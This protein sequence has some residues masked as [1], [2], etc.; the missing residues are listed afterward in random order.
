MGGQGSG[1]KPSANTIVKRQ[2]SQQ[3]PV[4]DSVFLPDY[5]GV[6]D[7]ALKTSTALAGSSLWEVD[8]T[9][10]QLI[11]ADEID[12]QSKNIINV[13]D[14]SGAQDAATK[15][16][17][18]L[19]DTAAVLS[20]FPVFNTSGSQIDKGKAVYVTGWNVGQSAIN[21]ELAD[22]NDPAKMPSIG[23]ASAD[24]PNGM[25]GFVIN[26]GTLTGVN[27][28]AWNEGDELWIDDATAGDL[29]STK[30]LTVGTAIQ[31]IAQVGRDNAAGVLIVFGAGRS[32]DVPNSFV[33]S[34][35]M[36]GANV[37]GQTSVS[38]AAMFEGNSNLGD[39][40]RTLSGSHDTLSGSYATTSG[41]FTTLS[42]SHA[43]LS[44]A[45]VAHG[46]S[47]TA[48]FTGD[49]TSSGAVMTSNIIYSTTAT[50]TLPANE[51]TIGTLYIQYT[52]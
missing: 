29:T 8:G 52:P 38:G 46:Q 31:K 7:A 13:T 34:G 4:G 21:I 18:D 24:I 25:S 45:Y 36:S 20:T 3:T 32:N 40:L 49:H 5:S 35:N 9:E 15:A 43:V 22:S 37:I 44:G 47:G 10:T 42:G 27:T 11:A 51:T 12:M 1:R 30:P 19:G 2:S 14:P 26:N 48:L 33:M 17:V 50:T 41:A 28:T 16:Y 39:N 6:Q 23:L